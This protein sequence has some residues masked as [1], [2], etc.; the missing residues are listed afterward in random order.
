MLFKLD[1]TLLVFRLEHQIHL[2]NV[3]GVCSF[4]SLKRNRI[5]KYKIAGKNME[6]YKNK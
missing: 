6:S 1:S 5:S 2:I 4:V 3:Y